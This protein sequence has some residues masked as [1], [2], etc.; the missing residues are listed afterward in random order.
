EAHPYRENLLALLMLALYRSG[1]Q[2]D[3]LDAYRRAARRLRDELG[4]EPGRTLQQLETS[5]LRQDPALDPPA[6]A[7]RSTEKR[8]RGWKLVTVGAA[9]LLAAGAAAATIALT[10]GDS[11]SL[12][13]LP[14]G[15]AVLSAS[16]GSL[17]S[18][19][20]TTE[21]PQPVEAVTG[22]GHFWVWGLKP[23]Q[24]VEI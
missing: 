22:N 16:D 23:F 6:G 13:S 17:V 24:L 21:I 12:E 7:V 8:K 9:A 19:I 20:S 2:A 14:S 18:H 11:A 5:I 4:L 3:A 10:R 15:V 1:R